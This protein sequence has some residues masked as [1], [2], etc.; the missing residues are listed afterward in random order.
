MDTLSS[1]RDGLRQRCD[2]MEEMIRKIRFLADVSNEYPIPLDEQGFD[3]ES[4]LD[5]FSDEWQQD[6]YRRVLLHPKI[7]NNLTCV[8]KLIPKVDEKTKSQVLDS[9]IQHDST[10]IL[11]YFLDELK[12]SIDF[13]G[14]G[15]LIVMSVFHQAINCCRILVERKA[16][17]NKFNPVVAAVIVHNEE[18]FDLLCANGYFDPSKNYLKYI[19]SEIFRESNIAKKLIDMNPDDRVDQFGESLGIKRAF[20]LFED[21]CR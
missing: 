4:V 8:K 5:D 13:R 1:W 3:P 17:N 18:I 20:S 21:Y 9:A 19:P 12:F 2:E 11:L 14:A 6:E 16:V 10:E 7:I 15:S